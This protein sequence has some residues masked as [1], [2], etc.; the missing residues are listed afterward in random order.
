M[1]KSPDKE[2]HVLFRELFEVDLPG[3]DHVIVI[4]DALTIDKLLALIQNI[5]CLALYETE[6]TVRV[7]NPN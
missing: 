7:L 3:E 6:H 1:D 4:N 5:Q 2:G